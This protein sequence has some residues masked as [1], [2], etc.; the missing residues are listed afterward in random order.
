MLRLAGN[1]EGTRVIDVGC[2]E[3]RFC[4]MLGE[5]GAT[6][7]GIDPTATL[8]RAA[9]EHGVASPVRAVAEALPFAASTFDLA[10]TYITLVDIEHYR[11]AIAEMA[12]VLRP[13]GRLLA[14]NIGFV[15]A[16]IEANGGWR[17]DDAGNRLFVPIDRYAEEWAEVYDWSGIRIRNYHRPLS[18]YMSAYLGAGLLLREFLEPTPPER[19]RS[20]P[21]FSGAFRVPWFNVM[22]WQK[23]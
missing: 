11:E 7:I 13:G 20:V 10:V 2:G 17:R 3:G 1:V 21:E 15:S 16:S 12:R 22:L 5:R 18:G 4:R 14:A 23:P 6:C 8:L 9:R 19:F